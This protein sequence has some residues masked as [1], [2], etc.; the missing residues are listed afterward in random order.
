MP[1]P[2]G[3]VYLCENAIID[4]SYSNTIDFKSPSEQLSYWGSLVKYTITDFMY[5]RRSNAYIKVDKNLSDLDSI[6]YLYF[7]AEDTSKMYFCFVTSK[8]YISDDA[9]YIY[10]ETDVLQSYMFDYE[11]KESYVV[12]EHC[13]R[14]TVDHKPIFSRTAESLDY[15]SEYTLENAF[16]IE[17]VKTSNQRDCWYLVVLKTGFNS[18]ADSGKSTSV[19]SEM[20]KCPSPYIYLL[21]GGNSATTPIKAKVRGAGR[22]NSNTYIVD[23]Y[24]IGIFQQVV[25]TSD[26]GKFITQIIRLPYLPFDFVI[27]D[28]GLIIDTTQDSSNFSYVTLTG[29]GVTINCIALD[30]Y[31]DGSGNKDSFRKLAEMDLLEGLE[32]SVPTAEQWADVKANP[33]NVERDRRFESK[34]LTHPYR[35][36]IFTDWKGQPLIIKN[37]YIDSEKITINYLQCI[38]FNGPARYWVDSYRKDPEGRASSIVQTMQEDLPISID[39]YY[40]YML[41]N[42]NQ[43]QADRSNLI[44][45]AQTAQQNAMVNSVAGALTSGSLGKMA[46]GLGGTLLGQYTMQATADTNYNNMIRSQN[47]VQKDLRNLPDTVVSSNDGSFNLYDDNRYISFYRMKICC[48]FEEI[49][50]DTFAMS[51][52]TVK[53]VKI[54]NLRSRLRYNYIKTI[55]ANIVGSINQN[56]LATIRTIFNNG[57]TF[58]HYN[59]VNFKPYDYSLENIET[60]LI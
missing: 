52:Y 56:D 41:Q 20:Y 53:R 18:T 3:A 46:S 60:S 37:E 13:D 6:N 49:L 33:Y 50:A 59:T 54:P 19:P 35:Y 22:D 31:T 45:S 10:F 17:A 55:G 24:N 32:N 25:A 28:D 7:R 51:G 57:V 2:T 23:I 21:V 9:S 47:A 44:A 36:N 1:K 39:E 38:G 34:L 15:G 11:V 48:E 40:T 4:N 26:L 30:F 14:W 43:I 12:Q 42:R 29:T 16:N 58:W 8:E 27:S 5:I